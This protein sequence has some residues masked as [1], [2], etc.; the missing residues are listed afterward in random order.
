[1]MRD[2]PYLD[3]HS[4]LVT[5][6]LLAED[7]VFAVT[8][9][10]AGERPHGTDEVALKSAR[11]LLGFIASPQVRHVNPEGMSNLSSSLG[12]LETLR[13]AESQRPR[14]DV[15]K[16][17]ESLVELIDRALANEDVS[18]EDASLEALQ[19]LFAGLGNVALARA[20]S[21]ATAGEDRLSWPSATT[22]SV[23]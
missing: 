5:T 12:A 22:T 15:G 2:R 21:L 4:D 18:N 14:S 20:N 17:L 11:T 16:F 13:V 23:S 10:K 8:A 7:V 19:R 1:M 9:L 6:G 3:E